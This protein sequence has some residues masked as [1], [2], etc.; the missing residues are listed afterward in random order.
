MRVGVNYLGLS[1][2]VHSD[3][4]LS[5]DFALF[6]ETGCTDVAFRVIWEGVEPS[7][8]NYRGKYIDVIAQL[9]R[10][11]T[12]AEAAGLKV[13]IDFHTIFDS[14]WTFPSWV[15]GGSYSIVTNASMQQAFLDYLA[16]VVEEL[17]SFPAVRSWHFCNEPR[18]H[19]ASRSQWN[20]FFRRCYETIKSLD[21]RPVTGRFYLGD[22][23]F[24]G[25]FDISILD[26]C[27]YYAMNHYFDPD[28]HREP[29][30][31]SW[32]TL[33]TAIDHA[34]DRGKEYWCTEYGAH[35]RDLENQRRTIA[36]SAREFP[37]VGVDGAFAWAWQP[38]N[39]SSQPYNLCL[40][41]RG[42]GT[43]AFYEIA[44]FPT[45][46][47]VMYTLIIATTEGGTTDPET[48]EH[49]FEEGTK[50]SV[51]AIPDEGYRFTHW[52]LNEE[53]KIENPLPLT[54]DGDGTLTAFFVEKEE[55]EEEDNRFLLLFLALFVI[56]G[57]VW[58]AG[59]PSGKRRSK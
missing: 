45:P 6:R 46:P 31:V 16:H 51:K 53:Q 34:H 2:N 23:P 11:L 3:A 37:L 39:I 44:D 30:G 54:I 43:P 50:L 42:E 12:L 1:Y 49:Q 9:K 32:D 17:R 48:G 13:N 28:T 56:L 29:W 15:T 27:D 35:F 36:G 38:I 59:L 7:R 55:E 18:A 21:S 57:I 10:A 26:Y 19:G 25:E 20:T 8:G 41:T 47:P 52:L 40:N 24:S 5:R 58:I 22:S 14:R 4:V 33:L